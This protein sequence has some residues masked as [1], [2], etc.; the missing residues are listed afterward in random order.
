MLTWYTALLTGFFGTLGFCFILQVPRRAALPA[1]AVG[2]LA[3]VLCWLLMLLGMAEPTAVFLAAVMGSL[4]AQ[5]L[6]R[7]MHMVATIFILMAIVPTVPGLGLYRFM[8]HLGAGNYD[9]A[10]AA[11]TQAMILILVIS[12]GVAAGSIL[13]RFLIRLHGRVFGRRKG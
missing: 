2:A 8:E 11:G 4:A 13:F 7:R 12:L 5:V 6:A 1:A 10:A 9:I 3:Q